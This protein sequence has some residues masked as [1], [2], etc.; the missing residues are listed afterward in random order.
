MRSP[1]TP[2]PTAWNMPTNTA[3]PPQGLSRRSRLSLRLRP[4]DLSRPLGLSLLLG[5][6]RQWLPQG[7]SLPLLLLDLLLLSLPQDPLR[8]WRRLLPLRRPRPQDLLLLSLPQ[9]LSRQL[10]PQGLLRR[11]SLSRRFLP[12]RLSLPQGLLLPLRRSLLWERG[13][14]EKSRSL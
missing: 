3:P 2:A 11:L 13:R 9:G 14:R 1:P 8:P 6:L 5:R 4:Q 12:L 10:L 7:L